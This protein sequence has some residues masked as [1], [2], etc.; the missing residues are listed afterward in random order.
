MKKEILVDILLRVKRMME[1]VTCIVIVVFSIS[2]IFVILMS[3]KS[4]SNDGDVAIW[5]YIITSLKVEVILVVIGEIFGLIPTPHSLFRTRVEL[6]KLE[7]TNKENTDAIIQKGSD[8]LDKITEHL[9]NKY[10]KGEK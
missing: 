10:F 9:E 2:V 4:R 6:M 8:A 7:L 1:G 3:C 5:G